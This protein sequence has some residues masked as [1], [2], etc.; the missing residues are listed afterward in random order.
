MNASATPPLAE[1]EVLCVGCG[2]SLRGLNAEG[3]CPECGIPVERSL[4]DDRLANA[5]P[6]WLA[7]ICRGQ[8]W[9]TVGASTLAWTTIAGLIA[10]I[11]LPLAMFPFQLQVQ[12]VVLL[13][14]WIAWL[15]LVVASLL[16]SAIGGF[17]VTSLEP[18]ETLR[19]STGSVRQIVRWGFVAVIGVVVVGNG[20]Q[21]WGPLANQWL[22]QIAVVF[23]ALV[24]LAVAINSLMQWLAGIAERIPDFTLRREV[25]VRRREFCGTLI[26]IAVIQVVTGALTAVP[27]AANP[28]GAGWSIQKIASC[29]GGILMLWLLIVLGR[30]AKTMRTY[31][32]RLRACQAS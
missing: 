8:A 26:G 13:V 9:L 14:F 11:L 22:I 6:S 16:A 30:F 28:S 10:V 7:R 20:L 5:E 3:V 17:L 31:R 21:L 15:I 1:G 27:G 2:Y 4:V 32:N 29:F 25:L 18:R 19:E 23:S 12:S 24:A